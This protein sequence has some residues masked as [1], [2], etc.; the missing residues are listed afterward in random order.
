MGHIEPSV[1]PVPYPTCTPP[2]LYILTTKPYPFPTH[3]LLFQYLN[4]KLPYPTYHIDILTPTLPRAILYPYRILPNPYP[5]LTQPYPR[6]YHT[7]FLPYSIGHYPTNVLTLPP[8]VLYSTVLY[9]LPYSTPSPTPTMHAPT[10]PIPLLPYYTT[11]LNLSYAHPNPP[12]PYP[13]AHWDSM[14][15]FVKSL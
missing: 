1:K 13:V 4:P 10:L 5:T 7:I 2:L 11:I 3:K 9:F 6:P 8:P 14:G 15:F 12:T